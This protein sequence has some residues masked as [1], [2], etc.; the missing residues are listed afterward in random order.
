[1]PA[2]LKLQLRR[3]TGTGTG[4]SGVTEENIDPDQSAPTVAILKGATS[5]A[6]GFGASLKTWVW[7]QMGPLIY[8]PHRD[9]RVS[10]W[11]QEPGAPGYL[12][13]RLSTDPQNV[14]FGINITWREY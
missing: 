7:D 11:F 10:Q 6:A 5:P 3:G 9:D 1:M 13:L 4:H 12:V 14:T 8:S 2:P